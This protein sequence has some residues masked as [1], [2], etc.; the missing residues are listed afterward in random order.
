MVKNRIFSLL[1]LDNPIRNG[2]SIASIPEELPRD[3]DAVARHLFIAISESYAGKY[4]PSV[5]Y[6]ILK[7][8]L[9]LPFSKRVNLYG[10]AI[11]NGLTD[12]ITQV[13]THV[14]HNYNLG[15]I[16]EK[17]KTHM[18]KLQLEAIQLVNGKCTNATDARV[19]LL[20]FL[21]NVTGIATFY[22]FT[23]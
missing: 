17:Q 18:E 3:Q 9:H 12:P 10:L 19:N 4:V 16:N 11:G 22:D 23:K 2:F 20:C 7:K 13:G 6:Y 21:V 14:L 8:K 1:F 5:G 15:L